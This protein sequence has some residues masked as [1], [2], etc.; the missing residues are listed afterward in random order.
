[1]LVVRFSG[2]RSKTT[3]EK[4]GYQLRACLVYA[5]ILPYQKFGHANVLLI[6]F[7]ARID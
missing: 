2:W 7:D 4:K 3:K 5:L 6:W 1:M